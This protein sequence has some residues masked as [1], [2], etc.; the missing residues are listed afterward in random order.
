MRNIKSKKGGKKQKEEESQDEEKKEEEG[1]KKKLG[2]LT[3][4]D[5]RKAWKK[6]RFQIIAGVC[7][8]AGLVYYQLQR[9]KEA[10]GTA[11]AT[12]SKRNPGSRTPAKK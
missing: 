8:S 6:Y 4:E 2:E 7:A 12:R 5:L 9:M 3:E 11:T 10:M 1:K